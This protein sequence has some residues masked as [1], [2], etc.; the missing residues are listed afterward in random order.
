MTARKRTDAE[1]VADMPE[2][3]PQPDYGGLGTM[4]AREVAIEARRS[5]ARREFYRIEYVA[6]TAPRGSGIRD[7]GL[8][9]TGKADPRPTTPDPSFLGLYHVLGENGREY[10]VLIRD[11]NPEHHV[12]RCSCLDYES[13]NLGTCKHVEAVL[14]YIRRKHGGALRSARPRLLEINRLTV[15][16]TLRYVGDGTWTAA[17][18]YDH[19]LDPGLLRIVNHYLLPNLAL[20]EDQPQAFLK[21]LERFTAEVEEFGGRAI[22]EPEVYDYAE[23]VQ[24][25]TERDHKR[26]QLLARIEASQTNLDLLKLPLYPYQM[27]GTLFLAFTERALLADDMGLGKAQPLT[28]KVLTPYG[29]E[30]MGDVQVGDEVINSQGGTSHVIGVYPQGIKDIYRV[31]FTDGSCTE[32]C[33]EHLWLVNTAL[34]R[35]RGNTPRVKSLKEI[36]LRIGNG[37]GGYQH[38]IPMIQ[39]VEF[40]EA[41]L[42]LHPYLLGVL[43]GDGGISDHSVRLSSADRELLERVGG[44]LPEGVALKWKGGYDWTISHG[45][46]RIPNPVTISLRSLGLMGHRAETKFI[47]ALYKYASVSSRVALLQGLLDT[48]G[49][50]RPN[51]N[52]VEFCSSSLRLSLDVIELVQSLGGKATLRQKRTTYTYKGER[53]NGQ[54]AYRMS[55]ALPPSIQPFSLSRK[56]GVYHPRTKYP[57]VRAIKSVTYVGRKEAQCIATDAPDQ[58]YVSDDYI[59]THNTPQ[60]IAAAQLLRQEHGIE[61][62]LVITP[63]SVKYQWGKEIERFSD[64]T[65]TVVGGSKAKREKQYAAGSFF[66]IMNYELMLR[67]R[68]H[69]LALRPD[70]VILDEAQRIK[71][72]R[73]KTTQAIKDLPSRF[74]FVL[75]GT[76]LENRLEELYSVV[77][78]LD[79]KLLGPPWQF[80][81]QH[82]VK[83]DWGGIIGYKDLEGVRR[84]I[85]PILLR[86]RKADVLTELPE[87]IDND[88]WLDL[89]LEQA[90]LYRPLEKQLTELLRA[91]EWNAAQSAMAL[92]LLTRLR[93]AATAAQLVDPQVRSSSKLRELPAL[94]SEIAAEG[95]KMLIFSQWERM[96]RHATE[97]VVPLGLKSVRMHGGLGLR[98]RQRIVEQFNTDPD[99]MLFIST[100]AGGLG[101]NLQAASYVINLDLPWNPARVEQRIGRAHRIGQVN[102][103]NVIN[104]IAAN[105]V[106]QRVLEI[107]Y[108][109]QELFEEILDVELDPETGTIRTDVEVPAERLRRIVELLLG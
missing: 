33:D 78:F 19:Q 105:T 37:S 97:A 29:W 45:R 17:P 54:L 36:S 2:V 80:L 10:D 102:P 106:E 1:E 64:D 103:V 18:V 11:P 79:D 60:S 6:D 52:N 81:A 44:L 83:D 108:R 25:R 13:N 73:A 46:T 47:P 85:A 49:H 92:S 86:R 67:D 75:S 98:A 24:A 20:L 9:S 71:N 59:L 23:T 3:A 51:D 65:Y 109:K 68:E 101:L 84:A 56:A 15:Y 99:T 50:V 57:P 91:P 5:R 32:C 43:L 107:L 90:R 58:L 7:Q 76:P 104:I 41:E 88:F 26:R 95:H 42:P 34:R 14:G 39:P 74:A 40:A 66:T 8:A 94:V 77:E 62:V 55:I 70:L 48:D 12:N 27:I 21:K 22:I 100:D 38:F 82:V 89:D 28:A 69:V 93:E 53:R 96:T 30:L 87:R 4:I 63:A 72:W 61:H 35:R 16:V 31:E